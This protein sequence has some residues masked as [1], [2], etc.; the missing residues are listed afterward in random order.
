MSPGNR[1][2]D[3]T[4]QV[5]GQ[6][7]FLRLAPRERWQ[8]HNRR[9][10]SGRK[11]TWVVLCRGCERVYLRVPYS[12]TGG[13]SKQCIDCGNRDPETLRRR[14]ERR[15]SSRRRGR[16]A[17][18]FGAP[19]DPSDLARIDLGASSETCRVPR[20]P[21]FTGDLKPLCEEHIEWMPAAQRIRREMG[22]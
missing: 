14:G 6:W 18:T 19:V 11:T 1:F 16:A 20:C 22:I 13:D 12:I 3:L 4:G 17:I 7:E 15:R 5:F 9:G 21:N 2:K 10:R 8:V